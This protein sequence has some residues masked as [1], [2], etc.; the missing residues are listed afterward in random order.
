MRGPSVD[1]MDVNLCACI[2]ANSLMTWVSDKEVLHTHAHQSSYMLIIVLM[3]CST[4]KDT[5]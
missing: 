5:I 1:V 2:C 4:F 3:S